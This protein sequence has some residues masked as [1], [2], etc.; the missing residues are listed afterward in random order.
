MVAYLYFP[1]SFEQHFPS[2]LLGIWYHGERLGI[3][4]TLLDSTMGECVFLTFLPLQTNSPLRAVHECFLSFWSS[5]LKDI[6]SCKV[7][8]GIMH[9]GQKHCGRVMPN[10]FFKIS[11]LW[12][13]S[14]GK[15]FVLVHVSRCF[16]HT[17]INFS[18]YTCVVA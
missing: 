9:R 6:L 12:L 18:C 14:P 16:H 2:K 3:C 11:D 7:G 5:I 17:R 10:R 4:H 13:F 15:A 8:K 1:A